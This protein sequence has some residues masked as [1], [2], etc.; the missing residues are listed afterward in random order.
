MPAP[1]RGVQYL[2][3]RWCVLNPNATNTTALA[4]NVGYACSRADCTAMGYGCSCGALDAAAN[5]SYAFNVYYQAQGQAPSA[6]DF[7]GLAVVT[8]KDVSQPPCNFSVQVAESRATV[9]AE[10]AESSA[11][12]SVPARVAAVLT[13]VLVLVSA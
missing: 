12:A 8:D 4:D 2:Q 3:R 11:P 6:C 10:A 9:V 7:Q 5:A 13:L 1:A